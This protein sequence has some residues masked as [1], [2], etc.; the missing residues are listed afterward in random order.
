MASRQYDD[1]YHRK[2]A[3]QKRQ[4]RERQADIE[5]EKQRMRYARTKREAEDRRRGR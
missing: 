3:D 4:L 5:R 2:L 1:D